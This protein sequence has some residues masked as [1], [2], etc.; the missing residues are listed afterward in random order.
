MSRRRRK[1]GRASGRKG[2]RRKLLAF[3]AVLGLALLL[4]GFVVFARH[5]DG[6]A[7]PSPLPKADGVVVWTGKGGG[8]LET[9]G[10]L[11]GRGLGERLLVSGV[12]QSLDER[13]VAE[14]TGLDAEQASCCLDLDY[15]ALDT[16]GNA[17]ETA[18][19]AE[20]LGYDHI[21]LVTSAYHMP[22]ARVEIGQARG[23]LRVTPVP[24][25]SDAPAWYTDA[26]RARR[27][28]GEYGKYLLS[29][30]RGRTEASGE[31]EPVVDAELPQ[32]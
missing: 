3:I 31:R 26:S 7:A 20:A 18:R 9:A 27:L 30:A 29:L 2:G 12:N 4:G 14:L 16:R 5:V 28:A 21:L 19:W 10:A 17:A 25:R 6:L 24:V 8:R 13:A 32:E 15:A 22:R 23:T 11:M 1:A